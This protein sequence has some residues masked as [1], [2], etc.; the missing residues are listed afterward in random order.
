MDRALLIP[1]TRVPNSLGENILR[2]LLPIKLF[3]EGKT[4]EAIG[5]VDSGSD[6]SILPYSIGQNLGLLWDERRALIGLSGNLRQTQAQGVGLMAQVGDFQPV[7][8][9]F[10]WIQAENAPLIL[11][12]ISFFMKYDVCF[13]RSAEAFDI[14]SRA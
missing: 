8:L 4:V 2:P 7:M 12:Q 11:G 5:L 14:R 9:M 10:A 3:H 6:V 13:H 1:Y